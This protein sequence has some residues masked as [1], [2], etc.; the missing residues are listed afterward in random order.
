[1]IGPLFGNRQS[2]MS[3]TILLERFIL[4]ERSDVDLHLA[5]L[6]ISGIGL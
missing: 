5:V 6:I 1:M 2:I 4:N 3:V